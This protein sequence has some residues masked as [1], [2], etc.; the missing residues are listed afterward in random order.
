MTQLSRPFQIALVAM[1]LLA[2]VWFLALRGH[3]ATTGGSG[4]S[5]P[6]AATSTP[7]TATS[8]PATAPSTPAKNPAAPSAVYHGS[9]PGVEGLTRAIAKAHGAV[10][11][12]QRNAKR[13]EES[14]AEA[15][16]TAPAGAVGATS[17]SGSSATSRPSSKGA[18]SSAAVRSSTTPV[19]SSTVQKNASAGASGRA[20]TGT[21]AAA[22]PP[23]A[24]MMT[25]VER[26]LK[27]GKVV[28]VLFWNPQGADDVAVR[29]E[30]DAADR[31]L[32][33]KVAVHEALASQVGSFG[34]MTQAIPVDETPTILIVNVQGQE[35]ALTGFTDAFSIEQA[36]E[37]ARHI[38][39]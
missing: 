28:T 18:S 8:K 24:K 2:A 15:S 26:Q 22:E 4:S 6:S 33:G 13:V 23:A 32:G 3:P 31:A 12:S 27:Q 30:L 36:I 9:A 29:H 5:A 38:S 17:A 37:E 25:I 20:Q 39:P 16:G 35:T 19:G 10:A 14:S 34:A 7:A 21:A 1:G 11:E